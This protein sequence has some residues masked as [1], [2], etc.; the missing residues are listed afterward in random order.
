MFGYLTLVLEANGRPLLKIYTCTYPVQTA[1]GH[2]RCWKALIYSL[3]FKSLTCIIQA[4]S[5][6][7]KKIIDKISDES[8]KNKDS[9]FMHCPLNVLQSFTHALISRISSRGLQRFSR[10]IIFTPNLHWFDQFCPIHA[11]LNFNMSSSI[12]AVITVVN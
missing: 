5:T 8:F 4:K 7:I 11:T 3:L 6:C 2:K 1:R 9:L 10:K 12:N